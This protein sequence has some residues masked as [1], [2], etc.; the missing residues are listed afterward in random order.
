MGYCAGSDGLLKTVLVREGDQ[1]R[2][3]QEVA[4]IDR[5]DLK[6]ND[7]R[8][9]LV[10]KVRAKRARGCYVAAGQKNAALPPAR[11][12]PQRLA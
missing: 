8:L 12:L 6:R 7:K 10:R 3:G 1:V 11:P 9:W 5:A 2:A 4:V